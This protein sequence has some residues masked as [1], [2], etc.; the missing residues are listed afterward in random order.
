VKIISLIKAQLNLQTN[1]FILSYYDIYSVST[2]Y[3]Y[4]IFNRQNNLIE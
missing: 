3:E 2:D 4:P 1:I